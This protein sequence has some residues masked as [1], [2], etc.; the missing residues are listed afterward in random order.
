M[1]DMAQRTAALLGEPSRDDA[2][3]PHRFARVERTRA[4]MMRQGDAVAATLAREAGTVDALAHTLRDRAIRHVV[5]AGCGDSFHVGLGVRHAFERL[6]GVTFEAAQALD[7]AARR[8]RPGALWSSPPAP[9][10]TRR[11]CCPRSTGPGAAA[12]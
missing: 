7:Y 5:V 6:L 11:P 1:T 2:G 4:E 3:D 12:P 10:P 9:G 8:P